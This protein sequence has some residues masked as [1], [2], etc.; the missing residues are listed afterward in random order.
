MGDELFEDL[1]RRPGVHIE[2]IISRGHAT[3]PNQHTSR[4]GT[5]G[6]GTAGVSA[7][8]GRTGERQLT[9]GGHLLIPAGVSHLVTHTDDPTT[10]LALH[11]GK[12]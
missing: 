4:F 7:A 11:I 12:P 8:L 5:S 3:P 9:V 10:Q 6:K 1:L 2:R